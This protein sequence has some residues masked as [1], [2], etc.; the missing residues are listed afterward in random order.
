V[1]ADL[2][3]ALEEIERWKGT[4]VRLD[5]RFEREPGRT[6]G[7]NWIEA[8]EKYG[9]SIT[10]ENV[11]GRGGRVRFAGRQAIV[12]WGATTLSREFSG[13][14]FQALEVTLYPERMAQAECGVSLYHSRQGE[15]WVGFHVGLDRAGKLWVL[16]SGSETQH[17]DRRDMST[18]WMPIKEA[19]PDPREVR[20]RI[21]R[22]ERNRAAHFTV[23]VWNPAAAR[24]T[25]ATR[26]IPVNLAGARGPWRVSIFGRAPDGQEYVFEADNVRIYESIPH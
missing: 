17:M 14:N 20:L 1:A 24:W 12:S 11:A 2:E 21:E 7:H 3:R 8:D 23:Y 26:E 19:P 18:G 9:I 15:S 5:E 22:G 6:V 13:E 25:P 10:L 16:P 4:A